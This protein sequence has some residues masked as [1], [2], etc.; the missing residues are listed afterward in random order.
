M[1]FFA[2]N[3]EA[4]LFINVSRRMENA[5]RPQRHLLVACLPREAD[6]LLNQSPANAQAS[7]LRFNVQ[8]SQ[9]GNFVGSFC[10]EDR[11][12]TLAISFCNPGPL[13]LRIV[14]PDE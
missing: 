5:L 6:A 12:H 4:C 11:A 13:A 3:L 9:L 2:D 8:Q 10:D 7:R 14:V 1:L